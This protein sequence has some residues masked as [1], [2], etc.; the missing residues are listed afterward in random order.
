M[1]CDIDTELAQE[2]LGEYFIQKA[3]PD[4]L[5]K[6]LTLQT[7]QH[8]VASKLE[9]SVEALKGQRRTHDVALARQVAMFLCRELTQ[10][11]LAGMGAAFGGRD[12]GT[13]QRSIAK[14][15]SLLAHDE[16]LKQTLD[17]I[18]RSLEG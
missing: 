9:I 5:R 7:I 3:L 17:E 8:A 1:R 10:E 16:T 15:E 13:V 4:A 2:V 14:I 6:G 12:H 11:T 18:R